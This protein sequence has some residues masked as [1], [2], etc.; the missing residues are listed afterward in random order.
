MDCS[1]DYDIQIFVGF[2]FSTFYLIILKFSNILLSTIMELPHQNRKTVELEHLH[3]QLKIYKQTY[4][5]RPLLPKQ[6]N[7]YI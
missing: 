5:G 4:I 3:H 2:Y 1:F 7:T 6:A